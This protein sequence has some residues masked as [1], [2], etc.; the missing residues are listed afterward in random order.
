MISNLK[1]DMMSFISLGKHC[2]VLELEL[3]AKDMERRGMWMSSR[4]EYRSWR[5]NE[6]TGIKRAC[7]EGLEEERKKEVVEPL[8]ILLS[9]L[10]EWLI[11]PTKH[12]QTAAWL[13]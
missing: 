4:G 12:S 1:K 2:S 7:S 8:N 3:Q 5:M 11:F 9:V 6:S 10:R 13:F